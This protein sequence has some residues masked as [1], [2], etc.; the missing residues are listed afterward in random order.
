MKRDLSS[1]ESD[2]DKTS[3]GTKRRQIPP[4]VTSAPTTVENGTSGCRFEEGVAE[5]DTSVRAHH[6][7][8]NDFELDRMS[9]ADSFR[10]AEG[11]KEEDSR[12]MGLH[13]GPIQQEVVPWSVDS[14]GGN[15]PIK[16][17]R[18]LASIRANYADIDDI[19]SPFEDPEILA[20][21]P[22][23]SGS[24]I[25]D[26][27]MDEGDILSSD[28]HREICPEPVRLSNEDEYDSLDVMKILRNQASDDQEFE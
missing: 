5:R 11:E 18:I 8:D 21:F 20:L 2:R 14:S 27:S 25:C 19:A 9:S 3:R 7:L 17:M 26:S 13:P 28:K 10:E 15:Y 4:E 1:A 24:T 23:S 16:S 12:A 22:D 6:N